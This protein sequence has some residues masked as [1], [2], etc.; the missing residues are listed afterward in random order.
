MSSSGS[1]FASDH[2]VAPPI[3]LLEFQ[4]F[5]F[6]Q[7]CHVGEPGHAGEVCVSEGAQTP[8]DSDLFF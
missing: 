3:V 7:H 1:T 4:D 8:H 2:R 6:G 5:E